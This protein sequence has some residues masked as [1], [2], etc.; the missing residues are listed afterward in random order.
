MSQWAAVKVGTGGGVDCQS[1]EPRKARG[2]ALPLGTGIHFYF[3]WY[4]ARR[5]ELRASAFSA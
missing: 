2:P 3:S 1:Q 4:R 5:A